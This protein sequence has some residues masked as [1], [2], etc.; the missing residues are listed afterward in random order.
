MNCLL[1][2]SI[3]FKHAGLFRSEH[4]WIHPDR[5]EETFEIIYVTHGEIFL[6]EGETEYSLRRG[7]LLLL[8]PNVRHFGTKQTRDVGFYWLHFSIHEGTLPFSQSVF[9]DFERADLF[10]EL[11]HYNNLPKIPEELVGA[12]LLHLLTELS[13]RAEPGVTSGNERAEKIYEWLRIN[14]SA[15]LK[16]RDAA[17]A[18]GYSEDHITRICKKQFGAG[19]RELIDRF[20]LAKA[21]SLLCNTDLYV[22]E[23]AASLGFAEDKSFLGFF[24]YHEGSSPTEFRNRFSKLRMNNK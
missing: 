24:R 5:T 19:A 17:E 15:T 12:V 10:K 14:A 2:S 16:V 3:E 21:K 11:L 20:L 22:K 9:F 1:H 18:F 4:P 7:D 6:Q 8:T 13:R 23:I